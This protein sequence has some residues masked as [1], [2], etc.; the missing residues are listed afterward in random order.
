MHSKKLPN[1]I[2]K[3]CKKIVGVEQKS[4]YNILNHRV[5]KSKSDCV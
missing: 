4:L 3:I 1:N 2:V 5:E